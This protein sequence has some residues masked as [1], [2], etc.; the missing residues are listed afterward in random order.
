MSKTKKR[1]LAAVVVLAVLLI[2]GVMWKNWSVSTGEIYLY[3]ESHSNPGIEEKELEIW[4][5]YYAAG[6]RDLF[7][8]YSY[9]DGQFLNLWMQSDNDDLLE[10]LFEDWKGT[11]GGQENNKKFLKKIKEDYPQTVFHGTDIEHMYQTTGPRY[12]AYLEEHGQKDSEEYKTVQENIEQ[13]RCFYENGSCNSTM[14]AK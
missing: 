2:A 3:G 5:K 11:A 10:Q 1:I 4:G 13:G 8:E 12:L 7:V 6:M 14:A 9:A